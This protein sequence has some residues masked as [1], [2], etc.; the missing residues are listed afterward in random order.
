MTAGYSA[1]LPVTLTHWP[2]KAPASPLSTARA[3]FSKHTPSRSVIGAAT[4]VATVDDLS[5][6]T[7]LM[8]T[9]FEDA[10]PTDSTPLFDPDNECIRR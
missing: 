5:L 1:S 7:L 8:N 4:G 3:A 9:G 6:R 10:G 2:S